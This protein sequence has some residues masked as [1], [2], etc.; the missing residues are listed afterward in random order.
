MTNAE[1]ETMSAIKSLCRSQNKVNWEQVRV[2]A[3][4]AAM[5]GVIIN[6]NAGPLS[7]AMRAVEYADALI[8]RLNLKQ[9]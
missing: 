5:Q 8:N 2:Q 9:E 1:L 4:I 7:A 3:A 6:N